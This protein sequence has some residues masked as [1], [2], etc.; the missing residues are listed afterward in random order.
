MGLE[1][2]RALGALRLSLGRWTT[3]ED[4]ETAAAALVRAASA[5]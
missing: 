2:E 4:V 3:P 1:K 5:R